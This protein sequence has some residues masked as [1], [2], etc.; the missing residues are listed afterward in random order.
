MFRSIGAARLG[1]GL[2]AVIVATFVAPAIP[3]WGAGAPPAIPVLISPATGSVVAPGTSLR[4][5]VDDPDD[6]TVDVRVHGRVRQTELGTP[7]P[8]APFTFVVVPDT[9]NYVITETNSHI[10]AQ[11]MNWILDQR[12]ELNTVFAAGVGDI[13]S[14]H[15]STAQWNRASAHL[16]ILDNAGLPNSVVPGNHD[17]DT[18]TGAFSLYNQYLPVSR[19]AAAGWNSPTVSYGG[20]MGQDQFGDDPVD[21]QN[22][23]NYSLFSASGMDFLVLSLELNAPDVTLDWAKRVLAA[24]P[25]RRAIVATH[26]FVNVNGD[27]TQQIVRTDGGGNSGLDIWQKLI[28]PSCSIFLVVNGHFTDGERGEAKRTD[29]NACG[30]PVHSILT[31]YQGRP[32]GGDGWLRYYTFVPAS[33]E[34]RAATYSP[35]LGGFESDADSSFVLPY[36]MTVPAELPVIN[37]VTVPAGTVVETPLPQIPD[38]GAFEWYVT[39]GDG[40]STT[41]GPTWTATASSGPAVLAADG[42]SRSVAAGWGAAEVGGGWSVNSAARFSVASGVGRVVSPAGSTLTATLPAVSSVSTDASAVV[43]VD[44]VPN[45]ALH[46]TLAGRVVGSASYGAR[47]KVN[48]T[49]SVQLH[50]VRDATALAGNTVPGVTV[51]AGSRL[52]VRV[53]VVGSSPT[54]VRARVWPDGAVEPSTWMYSAT[55]AAAGLQAAGAVRLASYLSSSATN[56]P[57]TVSVDELSVIQAGGSAPPPNQ[58]PDAAFT[59]SSSGLTASFEAA[60]STD[61]DGSIV[62][63]DWDFGDGSAGSGVTASHSYGQA[64]AYTVALTVTDDDGAVDVA[65][66]QVTVNAPPGPAVL[67]ADGF[68]RS[69]AAGWGAAEVGGGWSV[70]SA[71]RFS[72]A[73]GVGRVVSPAGS[74][75]T[76]TLPAVSSVSTDAS[77]V[78]AV[79]R[80]PNQALHLTLA[81]RVVGSASYGARVKVNPTGSVQLHLVRDATALAGN[82]VPGVTVAAG[83]RLRVRVQVV[84]SSPTTVRARVWP[85]GAVE[86]STWMYSATDAA[87]GLQAAGAVRL[88]SYL[89]SSATNGPVTVSVDELNVVPA[90]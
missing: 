9:Q 36:D 90:P 28:A 66:R 38:G 49:G 89:S 43:A 41:R 32:N 35:F 86:P 23:N 37:Q 88:A 7:N 57:V 71:A 84:G 56:G 44:R 3:A 50:L 39:V 85:D 51:A 81:G 59:A 18:A 63:R 5:Q 78:V 45:Q 47:V 1:V 64:G 20:Y 70:N 12:D 72:V 87:A 11:Q 62:S 31:D 16:A 67:A 46:L 15:I 42:F 52:R 8:A 25:T 80:V 79:D 53:Q 10:M 82:T 13:V 83:S 48:P 6:A 4:A 2:T 40:T 26:S 27:I 24:Y 61:P 55:D 58:P 21:R 76:A 30:R 14:N 17:F 75:L 69:V 65:T 34:I 73:S 60:G 68:S 33:N 22:M 77:A 29:S 74:T 54:T 19:Y